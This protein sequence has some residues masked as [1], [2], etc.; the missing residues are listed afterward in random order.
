MGRPRG[1]AGA[2]KGDLPDTSGAGS[3]VSSHQPHHQP[4]CWRVLAEEARVNRLVR[5]S[6]EGLS[7]QS[8]RAQL[9]KENTAISLLN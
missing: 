9:Q 5:P 4:Q 8:T 3:P 2:S 7:L 6:P 1:K